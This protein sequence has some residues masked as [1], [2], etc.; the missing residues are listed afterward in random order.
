[1]SHKKR[2]FVEQCIAGQVAEDAID[3]LVDRWHAGDGDSD[4]AEYL[5][6]TQ[7]EYAVWVERPES[8]RSI[9]DARRASTVLR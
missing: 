4:L 1:M 7:E 6:F 9:L 2:S 8:L 3:E 5:G